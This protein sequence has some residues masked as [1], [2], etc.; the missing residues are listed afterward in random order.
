MHPRIS[1]CFNIYH[2]S[3]AVHTLPEYN[4]K[5]CQISEVGTGGSN[6]NSD[7]EKAGDGLNDA[8]VPFVQTTFPIGINYLIQIKN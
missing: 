5:N 6:Q 2:F 4:N 3:K 8:M 1:L 7:N